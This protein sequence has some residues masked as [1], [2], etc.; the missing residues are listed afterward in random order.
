MSITLANLK[1]HVTHA[2]NGLSATLPPGTTADAAATFLINRA[3]RAFI[4]SHTWNFTVAP[5]RAL[6]FTE[7]IDIDDATWTAATKTIT[8]TGA[9]TNYTFY[10]GD[11]IEIT[12]GTNAVTGVYQIASR[13]SN[14]AITTTQDIGADDAAADI[15]GTIS[16]RN[17]ALPSDFGALDDLS[18]FSGSNCT[19]FYIVSPQNLVQMRYQDWAVLSGTMYGALIYPAKAAATDGPVGPVLQVFPP[20][21]A[22]EDGLLLTYRKCWTELSGDT[23]VADIP[24]WAESALVQF[25]RA[26]AEGMDD[27]GSASEVSL[28][29]LNVD[30]LLAIVKAGP[31]YQ[32]AIE[33]D[34]GVQGVWG[35]IVNGATS[36]PMA[37]TGYSINIRRLNAPN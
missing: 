17:I 8:S 16:I 14:N 6:T 36:T 33:Y 9:F 20:P 18:P 7:P 37:V 28:K 11:T 24:T 27:M 12:D 13:V 32:E 19:Q 31:I 23:D 25:V 15:D 10:P 5:P 26:F 22:T 4:T 21:A 35:P 1:S 34:G 2:I 3:G 30:P 29:G